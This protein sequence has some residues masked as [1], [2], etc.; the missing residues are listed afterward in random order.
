MD[1]EEEAAIDSPHPDFINKPTFTPKETINEEIEVEFKVTDLPIEVEFEGDG[2]ESDRSQDLLT[3]IE[4]PP[5]P[6][7]SEES[8]VKENSRQSKVLEF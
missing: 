5:V 1:H 8:P 3:E 4:K 7:P 2:F 6:V